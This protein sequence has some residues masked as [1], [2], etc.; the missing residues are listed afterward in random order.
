MTMG[1]WNES[2]HEACEKLKLAQ[3][4][5]RIAEGILAVAN[6]WLDK[7]SQ[8]LSDLYRQRQQTIN[9]QSAQGK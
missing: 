4:H 9:A 5:Y 6:S 1:T 2:Y 7:A 3:E 8:R